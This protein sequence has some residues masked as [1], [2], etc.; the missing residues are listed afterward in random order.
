M[1]DIDMN[2]WKST[3]SVTP[4]DFLE[5]SRKHTVKSSDLKHDKRADQ[6]LNHAKQFVE[7][8]ERARNTWQGG[9]VN[10]LP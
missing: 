3:V 2:Y 5:D 8:S 4:R 9:R 10:S 7:N 1:Y 6:I